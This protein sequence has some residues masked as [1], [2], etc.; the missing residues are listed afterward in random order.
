MAAVEKTTVV[1][2]HGESSDI[3]QRF[4]TTSALCIFHTSGADTHIRVCVSALNALRREGQIYLQL[5]QCDQH[6]A[7]T[8]GG[9]I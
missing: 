3:A 5:Q 8:N 9:C 6:G 2:S 7:A 4:L 1:T